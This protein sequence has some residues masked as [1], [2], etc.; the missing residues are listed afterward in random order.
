MASAALAA[1]SS[2]GE[3]EAVFENVACTT[4]LFKARDG[5]ELFVRTWS[6]V[7]AVPTKAVLHIAHGLAE[8]GGRYLGL[9]SVL[10]GHGFQVVAHDHRAHGRTAGPSETYVHIDEKEAPEGALELMARDLRQLIEATRAAHPNL[11]VFL[12]GHSMGSIVS[13]LC[14]G[15][16]APV[17]GLLLT[18]PCAR[19]GA[20]GLQV[21]KGVVSVLNAAWG[22]AAVSSVTK[23]LTFEKFNKKTTAAAGLSAPATEHDWLNRDAAEVQK[24]IDDPLCGQ[25]VSLGTWRSFAW[26][27]AK[28]RQ[29]KKL[30]AGM[31]ANLPVG[32]FCGTDDQ[33]ALDDFGTLAVDPITN[34]L[35]AAGKA[36][37]HVWLY[38]GAR[39][40]IL[41]ETNRKEVLSDVK[42]FLFAC[43]DGSLPPVPTLSKL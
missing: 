19:P 7:E 24:Y 13:Q 34:E 31:P 2:A 11:K 42:G 30:F 27:H 23:K 36:R 41:L 4:S 26:A 9:A 29:P 10:V 18:G 6:A 5:K 28:F 15:A 8:H 16:G 3:P 37:P 40:E 39:H 35:L 25:D 12:L 1:G 20:I 22:S 21:L 17:D 33:V 38:R 14:V 43:L 32:V